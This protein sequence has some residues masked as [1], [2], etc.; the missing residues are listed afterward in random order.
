MSITQEEEYFPCLIEGGIGMIS[1]FFFSKGG[2]Q[3][4]ILSPGDG[5]AG[6]SEDGAGFRL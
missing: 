6:R 2:D 5:Y 4:T 3:G 1:P